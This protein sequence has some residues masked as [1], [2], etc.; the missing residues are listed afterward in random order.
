[1]IK[2]NEG[3]LKTSAAGPSCS[4]GQKEGVL[5]VLAVSHPTAAAALP[6]CVS[7]PVAQRELPL[8]GCTPQVLGTSSQL[9]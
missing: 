7:A 3:S 1:M 2:T 4:G 5:A 8:Q 6:A 9:P